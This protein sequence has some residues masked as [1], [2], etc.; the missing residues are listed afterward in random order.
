M[1]AYIAAPWFT[2]E[3][4]NLLELVKDT[5]VQLDI[6]IFS[7]KDENMYTPGETSAID[8]LLGNCNAIE[9]SDL[10]VVIT[11][12]KDVGTMWEAGY[13][14]AIDRP[15]IY[16]WVDRLPGQKFNLMLAASGA[17]AYSMIE[18]DELL[19]N[20]IEYGDFLDDGL[21]RGEIE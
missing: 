1:R 21:N 15:I 19:K 7:P 18:L 16:V 11:N 4:M 17:V 5:V 3:Q 10:I 14:F 13:A 6:D 12:G 2:P 20:F 9:S 8:V